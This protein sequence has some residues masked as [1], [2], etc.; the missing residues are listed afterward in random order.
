MSTDTLT[1]SA[2]SPDMLPTSSFGRFRARRTYL[3]AIF[4][5]LIAY[6]LNFGA[7]ITE[8]KVLFLS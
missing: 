7:M 5:T 2:L 3:V 1:F 6:R 4:S 8:Q